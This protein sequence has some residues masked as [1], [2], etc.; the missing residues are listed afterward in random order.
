MRYLTTTLM[1]CVLSAI[2][3]AAALAL[4]GPAPHPSHQ[5]GVS[6]HQPSLS[7]PSALPTRA[8]D[9]GPLDTTS[10]S[11]AVITD[12]TT[13]TAGGFVPTT[14]V[15]SV[16]PARIVIADFGFSAVTTAPG[17]TVTVV[18]NDQVAHSVTDPAGL[19]DT[20]IIP[21]GEQRT[22][23]AP[24]A[25]GSY[26]YLCSVHPSMTGSLTVS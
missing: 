21:P 12:Q 11:G 2:T 5:I 20:G 17:A 26:A 13:R 25:P 19:F 14:P 22:F 7:A 3:A 18:N 15:P 8:A 4:P 1:V 23:I 10:T 24:G 16:T 9:G 6:D